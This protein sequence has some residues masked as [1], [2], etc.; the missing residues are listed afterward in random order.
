MPVK[1][2]KVVVSLVVI[3]FS[4]W[5]LT[6]NLTSGGSKGDPVKMTMPICCSNCGASYVGEASTL[7]VKCRKCGN[8]TAYRAALCVDCSPPKVVPVIPK[9]PNDSKGVPQCPDDCKSKRARDP[10]PEELANPELNKP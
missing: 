3:V 8:T 1:Q 6:R 10:K 5:F 4:I 9:D 2:A 7:P